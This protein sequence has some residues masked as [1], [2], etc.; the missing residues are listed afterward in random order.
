MN[1]NMKHFKTI[2]ELKKEID[3]ID[4]WIGILNESI[5]IW[6]EKHGKHNYFGQRINGLKEVA[7]DEKELL[8]LQVKKE[9]LQKQIANHEK[10]RLN[11][12]LR[13]LKHELIEKE[14]R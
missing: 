5:P 1:E 6:R 9:K 10:R 2:D 7:R 14:M 13:E 4:R 12:E 11:K 8:Q 3:K